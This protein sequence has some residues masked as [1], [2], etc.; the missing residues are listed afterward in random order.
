MIRTF[1]SPRASLRENLHKLA[2]INFSTDFT[3]TDS[4]AD[5]TRL[6][7]ERGTIPCVPLRCRE[8]PQLAQHQ[9]SSLLHLD[10]GAW[11]DDIFVERLRR[12]IKYEGTYLREYGWPAPIWWPGSNLMHGGLGG[13]G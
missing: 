1:P 11:R 9:A 4:P 12:I 6:Q 10:R 8:K 7:R 5:P 2:S 3:V 13:Y